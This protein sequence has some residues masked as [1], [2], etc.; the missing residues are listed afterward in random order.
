VAIRDAH[1]D[2]QK[3]NTK[4]WPTNEVRFDS[5][6]GVATLLGY[7]ATGVVGKFRSKTIETLPE[8]ME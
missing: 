1:N 6:L 8:L 3:N 4:A 7:E 5:G 2:N